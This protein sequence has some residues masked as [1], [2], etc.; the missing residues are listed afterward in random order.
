MCCINLSWEDP[1]TGELQDNTFHVPVVI[2]R[3]L[4]SVL[5][6]HDRK[7]FSKAVFDSREVSRFHALIDKTENG[8]VIEDRSTNGTIVNGQRVTRSKKLLA[9]GDTI[10]IG[11]YTIRITQ[12]LKES[13]KAQAV[14]DHGQTLMVNIGDPP[15]SVPALVPESRLLFNPETDLLYP[16]SANQIL[17]QALPPSFNGELVSIDNLKTSIR[18]SDYEEKDFVSIGGGIGSFA[19]VDTLR[20]AGVGSDRI[21]VIG[22]GDPQPY[23]RYRRICQNSQIP[24]YERLRSGSDSCPDN[25]WAFPSYAMREAWREFFVKGRANRA[26]KIFW[27]VFAEPALADTY[28]PR[29]KDVFAAMEREANRI[30]WYS[31]WQPGNVIAIRKTKDDRYV[32]VYR[33]PKGDEKIHKILVAS[34]IHLSTGYTNVRF[35]DDLQAYR[36]KTG[37]TRSVVN[38][39]EDHEHIYEHLRQKGGTVILRGEGIV[40]SRIIQR[41][42]EIRSVNAQVKVIH[43]V[44][45]EKTKAHQHKQ[46]RRYRE[47]GWEF[48]PFNWPK[49]TWGGDMRSL[50]EAA[51]PIERS[52][53]LRDW[54]GTTTASRQDWRHIINTGIQELWYERQIGIVQ[55]I[56]Q[57]QQG[58]LLISIQRRNFEGQEVLKA[59]FIVD[60]TGLIAKPK[61]DPLL[62]DLVRFY[63]LPL[64]PLDGLDVENNF[65][66]KKMRNGRGRF[67]VVGIMTLGGPYAPVDT[68]LGL[69]YAAHRIVTSLAQLRVRGVHY[70]DGLRSLIQWMKWVANQAP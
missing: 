32:I 10:Q 49:G 29:S 5:S 8:L 27:K 60:A 14:L 36:R 28:T 34:H 37:D 23:S 30:G 7:E 59:D 6:D 54:G 55:Q 42:Y 20:I 16:G 39:Y 31:M 3:D 4:A 35:L 24:D 56:E 43:L 12:P 69:Q 65:E 64:N 17:D 19:F 53:L 61:E 13:E 38:A 26:L 57:N 52:Q 21:R 50:L 66:L 48:Q 2:G 67:Y 47:N 25:I 63:R 45:S 9:N 18:P 15:Q 46:A 44:R 68:F 11:P 41:I 58:R 22:R 62:G 33:D 40:A 1:V 51:S 70:I